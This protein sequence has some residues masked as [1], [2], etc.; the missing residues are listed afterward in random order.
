[1]FDTR[2]SCRRPTSGQTPALPDGIASHTALSGWTRSGQL[3][4]PIAFPGSDACDPPVSC[5][6]PCAAGDWIT[7]MRY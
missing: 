6:A 2:V 4:S 3:P 1:V 5:V 7:G